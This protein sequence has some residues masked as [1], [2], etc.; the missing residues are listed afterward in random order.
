MFVFALAAVLGSF[1]VQ[2]DVYA[3][4]G[5]ADG[6]ALWAAG[7]KAYND[8][9]LTQ[10]RDLLSRAANAGNAQ[11]MNL[12]GEILQKGF[13]GNAD[14]PAA[15]AWYETAAMSGGLSEAMFSLAMMLRNGEGGAKDPASAR[16]WFEK[17]ATAGN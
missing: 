1:F 10:A 2:V 16:S 11:A 3:S 12:L 8:G 6:G 4:G 5:D 14:L 13:G 9:N 15:R 7:S 17:A